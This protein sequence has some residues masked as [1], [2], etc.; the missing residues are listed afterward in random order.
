[1]PQQIN[2]LTPVLLTQ[3]RHLSAYNLLRVLAFLMLCG[4]SLYS[5]WIWDIGVATDELKKTASLKL[6]ELENL[7]ATI[8]KNSLKGVGAGTALMQVQSQ[9]A[10]LLR[11]EKIVATLQQSAIRPAYSHSVRLELLAQTI[12]ANVWITQFS[13]EEKQLEITGLTFDPALVETWIAKLVKNPVFVGQTLQA[14]KVESV[15]DGLQVI[16]RSMWSFSFTVA[17]NRPVIAVEAKP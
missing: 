16:S 4:G 11:V 6:R 14:V 17:S 2:I 13:D 5:Y 9:R 10:E 8:K 12:P 7:Q 3:K 1:M 15:K